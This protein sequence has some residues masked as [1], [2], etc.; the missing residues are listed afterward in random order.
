MKRKLEEIDDPSR[1]HLRL[2][3]AAQIGNLFLILV[4][5]SHAFIRTMEP[6][7]SRREEARVSESRTKRDS[8]SRQLPQDLEDYTVILGQDTIIPKDVF[9]SSCSRIHKYCADAGMKLVGFQGARGPP[10]I[11][12]PVGPPGRRGKQG[13]V[14]PSG[15]VGEAGEEGPRGKDGRCNC[16]I[17][18]MYIHRVPIPGPP[19]IKIEEK[20][21]PYEVLVVKEV[22][23][24]K[25]VPFEPTPPGFAPPV[26]WRPGMPRPDMAKTRKLPRYTTK[27]TSPKPKTTKKPKTTPVFA[28]ENETLWANVTG[29]NETDPF[30]TPEPYLGPPTLG[31]NTR[32]CTLAAIGIPVMHAESQYGDVGSWMRDVS[33]STHQQSAKRWVTDGF[34][35][36]V[37]YEYETEVKL[38]RKEQIIKYYVDFLASGTGSVV[39]DGYYYY[40][41]HGTDQLVRYELDSALYNETSIEM[42][43]LDCDILPDHTFEECNDT[44]RHPWLYNRPHNY[45]DFAV[46]ENGLWVIYMRPDSNGLMV[47]KL[48]K[49]L[50]VVQTWQLEHVN[51]TDLADAFVM[52]GVL[53]GVESSNDRDTF[54][55][56][57]YDLYRNESIPGKVPWYNPFKGLSMLH[58]NP[59]DKRLYF[60]DTKKLLSVNVRVDD[61]SN[62]YEDEDYGLLPHLNTPAPPPYPPPKG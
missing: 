38:M 28:F 56:Y 26:G 58:Y 61:D 14:G 60:F 27:P 54:I 9:E 62:E 39:I 24:T 8:P 10:G 40:H 1:H 34:A 18:D 32:E 2:I 12:G 5:Y 17:P 35:S 4:L 36:P 25:L 16:S 21:V 33:P 11:M 53:Y 42:S 29:L 41:K 52:C 57:A 31:T 19:I 37:L 44:D 59:V 23:V 13:A 48:E 15:L 43:F 30:T 50:H 55:T 7:C 46:D 51:A 3:R 20:L 6:L 47:S 22:E 49:N 45:V